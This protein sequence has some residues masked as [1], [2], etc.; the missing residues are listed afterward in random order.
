MTR[1]ALIVHALASTVIMGIGIVVVLVA[2]WVSAAAII[3]A[4]VAGLVLGIPV[5]W[6]IAKELYER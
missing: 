1:L 2:G 5:A 6:L 4:I 3:G